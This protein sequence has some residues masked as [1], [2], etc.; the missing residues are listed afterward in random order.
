MN[1]TTSIPSLFLKGFQCDLRSLA[2]FRMALA[3]MAMAHL[4]VIL[5]Y[6]PDFYTDSGVW[7]RVLVASSDRKIFSLYML[8]DALWFQHLLIGLT[9]LCAF[10]MGIGYK[11]RVFT[12]LTW[13]LMLSLQLRNDAILQAGDRLHILLL[14]WAM[15]LP[16]GA[17][18][19]VDS[20]Y[21][22][23]RPKAYPIVTFA[24]VVVMIQVL[25][26][27]LF[28]A[29]L[30]SG[31]QWRD[32]TAVYNTLSGGYAL[33][34]A[35]WLLPHHDLMWLLTHGVWWFEIS[36]AFLL[37]SPFFQPWLRL[38]TLAGLV[39]MHLAFGLF[40]HI[41]LFPLD[42]LSSL[43][44]FIPG[45]LW[46]W[47]GTR[48]PRRVPLATTPDTPK[49]AWSALVRPSLPR[50]RNPLL[51]RLVLAV[52]ALH[53]IYINL[54]TV[55]DLHYPQE[56]RHYVHAMRQTQIWAMFA[57]NGGGHNSWVEAIGELPTG[58]KVDAR[59]LSFTP[60]YLEKP[61]NYA[62]DWGDNR[63]LKYYETIMRR[64][65]R[66]RPHL[67]AYLCRKWQQTHPD[68]PLQAVHLYRLSYSY[69]L[70]YHTSLIQKTPRTDDWGRFEC[71]AG[72]AKSA[73]SR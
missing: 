5:P 63:W 30:K 44:V 48:L 29:L 35:Q 60:N 11:T 49:R 2:L 64:S 6:I 26:L 24:T 72:A 14:F 52:F 73:S 46:N 58:Q 67:A 17:V 42:S 65:R 39:V 34:T 47:L 12:C 36:V 1:L 66:A 16:L 19:S 33:P 40:L 9:F 50:L 53:M 27:Y 7:P 38:V 21:H 13:L 71:D 43:T 23:F 59:R 51:L 62:L 4:V 41:G 31:D 8:S 10:C 32:G 54:S 57:P 61:A 3:G 70:F 68:Y 28:T 20:R 45:A 56:L 25:S 18:W 15:F 55:S 22:R 37:L 69:R